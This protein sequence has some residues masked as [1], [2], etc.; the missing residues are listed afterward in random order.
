MS[1][2]GSTKAQEPVDSWLSLTDTANYAKTWDEAE[3]GFRSAVTSEAWQA[4]V[5]TTGGQFDA[6]KSRTVK[7]RIRQQSYL[8]HQTANMWCSSSMPLTRKARL[9]NW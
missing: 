5:E 3:T 4:A 7:V 2:A 6:F 8:A 9:L 1:V